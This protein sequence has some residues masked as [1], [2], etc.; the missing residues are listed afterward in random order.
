MSANITITIRGDKETA[1]ALK[2]ISSEFK[3][4]SVPLDRSSKKYL[5]SIS[6][7]YR[8]EGRTFGESWAPLSSATIAIKT[9]L[10]KQGKA[11]TITKPLVRTGLLRRSFG[12][13]LAGL[14]LSRIFN[15][16]AYA[17][18]HQEGGSVDFH[19]RKVKIPRRVFSQYNL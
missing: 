17:Q 9:A 3:N 7:N 8:D 5:N 11:I 13:E 14:N 18:I 15:T 16:Q 10:K 1:S 19:G 4:T 12:F 6:A 2:D